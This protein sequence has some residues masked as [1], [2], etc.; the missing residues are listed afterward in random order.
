MD[1]V[2]QNTLKLVQDPFGNYVVQFILDRQQEANTQK[3]D[4]GDGAVYT[5]KIITQML[6]HV[7]DLSCNKFSS[8]VIEKCLKTS[9]PHVRKLL[10]DEL[11]DPKTIPKLLTDNFANYVI[12]TAIVMASDDVQFAQLRDAILPLQSLLKNSPYGVKIES[13]LSR[14]HR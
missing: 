5:N 12:Q 11:T 10:V 7:A 4:N 1:G 3:T 13:K 14:R 6:H 9:L 2:L 8:N